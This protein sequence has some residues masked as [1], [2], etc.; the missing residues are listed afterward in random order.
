[1]IRVFFD[2]IRDNFLRL[3]PNI[4]YDQILYQAYCS[5]DHE[6]VRY[7]KNT[8]PDKIQL[9]L[10]L[11]NCVMSNYKKSL[12]IM[13]IGYRDQDVLDDL[14]RSA[15]NAATRIKGNTD[16]M[17]FLLLY[18]ATTSLIRQ[19]YLDVL[20]KSDKNDIVDLILNNSYNR[21]Y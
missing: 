11:R 19:E 8:H 14:F 5:F 1:V 21:L 20:R 6:T 12:E 4:S 3:N 9:K 16:I 10:H 13:L 17:R 18:G 15:V 2:T 7:I